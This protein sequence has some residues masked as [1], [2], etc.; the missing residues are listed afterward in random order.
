MFSILILTIG[1]PS[2]GKTSWVK[3]YLKTHPLTRVIS[4]DDLRKELTGFEQCVDPSQNEW[5][6][7]TARERVKEILKNKNFFGLGP[8]IIVDSTNVDVEEWLKYKELGATVILA[9]VFDITPEQALTFQ[10]NRERKVPLNIIQDKWNA[11]QKNKKYLP[12]IFNMIL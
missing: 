10:Q 1:I 7:N 11:L 3:E 4:T 9:K 5:I 8:E 6:H 12:L 2:S